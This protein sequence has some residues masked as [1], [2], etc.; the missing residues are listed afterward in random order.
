MRFM[1][2][3]C[4]SL[5]GTTVSHCGHTLLGR[6]NKMAAFHHVVDYNAHACVKWPLS[7][8]ALALQKTVKNPDLR[9]LLSIY[10]VSF[11]R[12]EMLSNR[13][14][15]RQTQLPSLRMHAEGNEPSVCLLHLTS[16]T[17]V[18]LTNDRVYLTG[19]EGQEFFNGFLSV[20]V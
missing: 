6:I 3:S 17:S 14:T 9:F 8:R 12:Q 1:A 19:N 15:D 11:V 5:I 7:G 4:F 20:A 10:T 16:R 2:L 13:Q 18:C